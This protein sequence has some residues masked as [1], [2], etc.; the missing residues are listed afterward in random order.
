MMGTLIHLDVSDQLKTITE[1]PGLLS[2]L[3]SVIKL[4]SL[5]L[6]L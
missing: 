1:E 2:Y 3:L 6:P 4:L 5:L